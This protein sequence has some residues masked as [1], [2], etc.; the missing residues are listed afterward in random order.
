[1][2]TQMTFS[3]LDSSPEWKALERR[4]TPDVLGAFNLIREC[5]RVLPLVTDPSVGAEERAMLLR[6]AEKLHATLEIV[7]A[8]KN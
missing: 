3:D 5:E 6:A 1:M 2:I 4:R 7:L 8:G